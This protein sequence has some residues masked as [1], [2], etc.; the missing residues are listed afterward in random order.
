[1]KLGLAAILQTYTGVSDDE[2][3]DRRWQLV[4]D[5]LA[6]ESPPFSKPTFRP[7]VNR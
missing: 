1:V 3:F 7:S 5:C 6:T 4:L 2:L